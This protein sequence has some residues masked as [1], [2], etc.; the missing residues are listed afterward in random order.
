MNKIIDFTAEMLEF[1]FK[2]V[3]LLAVFAPNST[4]YW[5]PNM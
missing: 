2:I 1:I 5:L 4:R 3:I